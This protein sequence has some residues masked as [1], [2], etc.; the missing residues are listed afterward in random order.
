MLKMTDTYVIG[1]INPDTDAVASAM[2]YAWFLQE[3]E[4]TN[5]IPARAGHLNPQTTWV[6]ERLGLAPQEY[7]VV[8]AHREEN[9]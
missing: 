8:S 5:V 3:Q 7:Y 2:G 1:H 4:N 6:L 9:V